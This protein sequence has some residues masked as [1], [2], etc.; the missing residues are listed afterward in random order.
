M[1]RGALRSALS[2]RVK[3]NRLIVIDEFKLTTA[4]TKDFA[5]ILA[6]KLGIESALI[7]DGVNKN[8]ELSGRNIARIRV[9]RTEGIN[10]YDIVKHPW[11]LVSKSAA[12]AIQK[13]LG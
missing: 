1:M 8:L 11:I 5:K 10:V 9:L 4:K 12:E 7:V 2:D 3:A 13:R 6:D